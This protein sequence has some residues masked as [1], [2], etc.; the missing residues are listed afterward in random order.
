MTT[1]KLKF[2][3]KLLQT[4]TK[5]YFKKKFNTPDV[6]HVCAKEIWGRLSLLHHL[7]IHGYKELSINVT[8]VVKMSIKIVSE[9]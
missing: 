5:I 4:C 6:C 7:K 3:M 2:L 9:R 1:L 8:N